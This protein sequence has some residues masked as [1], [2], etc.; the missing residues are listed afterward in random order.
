MIGA[1]L[2]AIEARVTAHWASLYDGGEYWNVIQ[3]VP[4]IHQYNADLINNTRDVA[5]S[6]QYALVK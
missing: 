4:D 2:A 6:F 5:K 3:S 1:D